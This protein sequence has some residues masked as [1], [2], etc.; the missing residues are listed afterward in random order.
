SLADVAGYI[1]TGRL[2]SSSATGTGGQ[3][4]LAAITGQ[5]HRD[6]HAAS[7]PFGALIG[8]EVQPSD[9]LVTYTY[10]GDADIDGQVDAADFIAMKRNFGTSTGATWDRADF[11]RDGNVDWQDLQTLT[12]NFG[13]EIEAV[14]SEAPAM[15]QPTPAEPLPVGVAA[16]TEPPTITAIPAMVDIVAESELPAAPVADVVTEP[17]L[18]PAPVADAV[19]EPEPPAAPVADAPPADILAMAA[20]I[21]GNRLAAGSRG[22]PPVLAQPGNSLPLVLVAGRACSLSIATSSTLPLLS[23]GRACPVVADVL[24]MAEPWWSGDP[25]RHELPDEPWA[26]WLAMDITGK[27]R[28]DWLDLSGMDVLPPAGRE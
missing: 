13:A 9:I 7:T 24:H 3:T 11:D 27:P 5:A 12:T 28:K 10:V 15:P 14:P 18:P 17:E 8:E 19:V 20:S 26:T 2:Y 6:M 16:S 25:A 21:L 1:A 22:V 23:L 4:C